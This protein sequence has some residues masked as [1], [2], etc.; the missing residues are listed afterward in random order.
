MSKY[1]G[2]NRYMKEKKLWFKAKRYG[3]GWYPSSWEGWVIMGFFI[4]A[5]LKGTWSLEP[6][7]SVGNDLITLAFRVIP[8]TI[9]LLIICYAK[10]EKPRWRWGK[11]T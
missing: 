9:F 3:W 4:Y 6:S 1:V 10:G 2:Y 5:I 8:P 11:N 7:D